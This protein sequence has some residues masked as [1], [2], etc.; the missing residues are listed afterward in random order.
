MAN[1]IFVASER[2]IRGEIV[3]WRGA[4]VRRPRDRGIAAIERLAPSNV[5]V[6]RPRASVPSPR[7]ARAQ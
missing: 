7:R 2:P 5:F 1:D 3:E 6:D 4:A